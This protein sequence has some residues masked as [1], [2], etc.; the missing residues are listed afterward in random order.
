MNKTL[1]RI[2]MLLATV[3]LIFTAGV[4]A[5]QA[6]SPHFK[7]GGS[8]VCTVSIDGSTARTTCTA[9]ITGLGNDDLLATVKVSGFAVY[10]CQNGGGNTAPGQNKV[11]VGPVT[12]PT[13][14]DSDAIKN[15]NLSLTTKE[16]VLTSPTT[17]SGAAAGCPNPNWTGV[18][19]V[20][21]VTDILLV[22]EQPVGT[23]I[24][25]CSASDPNGLTGS[26]ALTC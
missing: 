1:Q 22:I 10:Q 13:L 20:L 9:V 18:S 4:S 2:I 23:V 8:P 11:L 19:P 14:I 26:V 16:A 7:R 3:L 21:T 17:V 6:A 25:R 15:G 12:E 5:A 24:F